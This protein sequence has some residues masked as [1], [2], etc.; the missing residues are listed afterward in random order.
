MLVTLFVTSLLGAAAAAAAAAQS[1]PQVDKDVTAKFDD[2]TGLPTLG[3]TVGIYQ[4]LQFKNF[5]VVL[6]SL[7]VVNGQVTGV[8]PQSK[9]NAAGFGTVT[10]TLQGPSSLLAQYPGSTTNSFDLNAFF[11]GCILN[12]LNTEA[13]TPISC[14]VI[15]RGFRGARRVATS[16]FEFKATPPVQPMKK[17]TLNSRFERVDRVT[18]ELDAGALTVFLA[19]NFQYTLHQT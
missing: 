12:G 8:T 5:D 6:E 4:G 2:R 17:V 7:P 11:F 9:A 1:S 14:D 18:F 3:S 10:S 19:D 16:K 15:V 13:T